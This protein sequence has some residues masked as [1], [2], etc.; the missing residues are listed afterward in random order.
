MPNAVSILAQSGD[1]ALHSACTAILIWYLFQ[2][3][4]SLVTGRY[5]R[6]RF[7]PL[8]QVHVSILAQSGDWALQF[9]D[10]VR[11]LYAHVS[12]LAQSGDWALPVAQAI[13]DK[14]RDVSILAQS[15][16]WALRAPT[17]SF[18]PRKMFQ[19]SPSLVTGRYG[20][21]KQ[22]AA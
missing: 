21:P 17:G 18:A 9:P 14:A 11:K 10:G 13:W 8:L 6:T 16:D 7:A 5:Q 3:S 19:S 20:L 1:W 12:I 22:M 15:G 2:S 4:P